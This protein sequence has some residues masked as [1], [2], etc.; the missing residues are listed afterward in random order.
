MAEICNKRQLR[1]CQRKLH[2]RAPRECHITIPVLV[3][4]TAVPMMPRAPRQ[5]ERTLVAMQVCPLYAYPRIYSYKGCFLA[6]YH[7][8]R[9]LADRH[10]PGVGGASSTWSSA[11]T[12]R[13]AEWCI[14]AS[15]LANRLWHA[16]HVCNKGGLPCISRL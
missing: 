6:L 9:V 14:M 15:I 1:H 7:E 12:E 10:N 4:K 11:H 3:T 13:R 5:S 2:T 16:S 8:E